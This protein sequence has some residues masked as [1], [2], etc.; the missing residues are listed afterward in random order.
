MPPEREKAK[1][2]IARVE[3][4]SRSSRKQEIAASGFVQGSAVAETVVLLTTER[5]SE[6]LEIGMENPLEKEKEKA[7]PGALK[8]AASVSRSEVSRPVVRLIRSHA[9]IGLKET[10]A[11]GSDCIEVWVSSNLAH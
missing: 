2:R 11:S 5:R 8:S 1:V 3:T 6:A 10:A 4:P 9:E 7:K